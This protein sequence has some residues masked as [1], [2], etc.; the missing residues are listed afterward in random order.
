MRRTVKVSF[1]PRPRLPMTTPEKIWMRSLSPS[2]T[3]VCTRTLSPTSNS[4]LSL[5]NCSD[6]IF[7][8]NAWFIKSVLK[9]SK[10]LE[11]IRS[12][13]FRPRLRLL[14]A[15]LRDLRVVA[16]QQHVGDFH[17]AKLGRP[18]VLRI[19]QSRSVGAEGFFLRALVVAQHAGQ[20]PHDRV[21]QY[22]RRQCAVRQHIIADRQFV[23]RQ[24]LADP[25][26]EPF[27]MAG[28]EQ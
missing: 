27:V 17:P 9:N 18:R 6:S 8:S 7:S 11:Q 5:R 26:V 23:V 25:F 28:H 13:L 3:L 19:F 22:H 14:H 21:D 2:T 10:L 4:A 15:P 16:G 12:P 20:K 24:L 1:R